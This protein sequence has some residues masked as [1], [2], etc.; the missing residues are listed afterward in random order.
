MNNRGFRFRAQVYGCGIDWAKQTTCCHTF[1]VKLF[2]APPSVSNTTQADWSL[3]SKSKLFGFFRKRKK[4]NQQKT[5]KN[6]RVLAFSFRF[7]RQFFF[8]VRLVLAGTEIVFRACAECHV[9]V[10]GK[11]RHFSIRRY[12]STANTQKILV[13][14]FKERDRAGEVGRIKNVGVYL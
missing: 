2:P 13:C 1:S 14:S 10:C 3:M 8:I 7:E 5:Q 11:Q 12:Y 9:F 4:K 6:Q